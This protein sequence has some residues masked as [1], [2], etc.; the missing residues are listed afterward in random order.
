MKILVPGLFVFVVWC[1]ISVRWYVCGIHELC[2]AGPFS[3]SE[4]EE[5]PRIPVED[6]LEQPYQAP[7]AFEWSSADP[8]TNEEYTNYLDSL[9]NVFDRDPAAVVEITGLYDKQELNNYEYD[10]LGLARAENT[11]QLL[12]NS[13]IKRSMRIISEMDD[14]S[15]G[16]RGKINSGV[17]FA[18]VPQE[19]ITGYIITEAKNKL[20]IHYPNKS[21]HPKSNP[22]IQGA[23]KKMAAV[24][25]RN[26]KKLLVVGHTDNYGEAL[27]NNKQGLAHASL[28]KDMLISYGMSEQ[29]VLAESEGEEMPL[30]SN[31]TRPGRQQNRRI[32]ISII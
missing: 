26:E 13:G 28:V 14:L 2:D 8:L 12:L 19:D 22:Q 16:L 18:L 30:V 31:T 25:I 3:N 9:K 24:A 5:K 10:N 29:N 32:E 17:L 27:D 15:S 7:L 21:A 4:V 23:L 6:V 11:K 20:V 1:A